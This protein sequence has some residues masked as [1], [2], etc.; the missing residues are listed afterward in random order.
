MIRFKFSFSRK[1]IGLAAWMVAASLGPVGA[2]Q[3]TPAPVAPVPAGRNGRAEG[4]AGAGPE[5]PGRGDLR[6]CRGAPAPRSRGRIRQGGPGQAQ[7]GP[8]RNRRAGARHR[9]SHPG[10][11]QR[12][13]TLGA[14]ETAIRRSLESRRGVIVE[15][16]AALQ[17]MGR[18]PPPAVLVRPEDMLEAVRASIMLGAVLPELRSEAEVLATDLAELVRLKAAIATDR[19]TLER[20]AGR[21]QPGAGRAL[22]PSWRR[23]RAVSPR[24]SAMWAPSGRKPTELARQA[25]TLKELID[26][27]EA[28]ITGAQRA[29]EEARKAA[30]AQAARDPREIRPGWP[31]GIPPAW[32]PRSPSRRRAG[33]CRV[34]SAAI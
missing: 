9:G 22:Q 26:R 6:Q 4:A 17:R 28:E 20:R 3:Q 23:G 25:G 18:R 32:R 7:C 30:E 8:D 5:G 11:E 24:S 21:P 14:S 34:P 19:T 33:C 2:Q 15:V 1:V 31:S 16:F 27:M 12:L 10:L 29:A 13:Q